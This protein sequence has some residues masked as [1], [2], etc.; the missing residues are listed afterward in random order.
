MKALRGFLG[1]TGYYRKFIRAYGQ[2][3][4]PL[5]DSLKKDA[6][7]WNEKAK[8]AFE[9][10]KEA[11]SQPPCLALLDFSKI[12]VVECDASGYGVGAILMQ[13]G[14]PLAFY[15][16]ALKGKALFLSTYEKELM[17]LVL[18]V[19]K[20]RPYLFGN[21]FVIKTDQQSLKHLLEQR[22]GTPMQQKWVSKLLSYHFVVEFKRG[23]ENL[24]AD[25]LSKQM[26]TNSM[27]KVEKEIVDIHAQVV[28]KQLDQDSNLYAISFPSPTW[29]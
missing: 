7:K 5:T 24:V 18:S 16:Q 22:I 29:C 14:R 8:L 26:D 2:I 3:A 12:F 20:W 6:F 15:S 9:K 4:S 11:C 27:T 10:L 13:G 28:T 1:L 23:K 17:E 25:A 19:K 21:T